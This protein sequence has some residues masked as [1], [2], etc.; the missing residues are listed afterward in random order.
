MR[1]KPET[2][3]CETSKGFVGYQV[4][5]DGPPDVVFVTNW[6][7]NVEVI[8]D[9]PAARRYLERLATIGRVLLIDKRGTGVSDP[10]GVGRV[11][12]VEEYVDDITS[13]M[14]EV[15]F[16]DSVLI[17]D[18]EG[19]TLALVLAATYPER[20]PSL[21]LINA[22]ARLRRDS[23][24]PIGAPHEVIDQLHEQWHS[25]VGRNADPLYVTAPSVA[26]DQ[27]FRA[28]WVHQVRLSMPPGVAGEAVRWIGDTD[29]RS[30]LPAIQARTLVMT[31]RDARLHRADFGRF[32]AEKISGAIYK[33][34]DGA[35]TLPF[36]A[37]NF[38][39]ILD[40]I[41]LFLTGE[42]KRVDSNR[43]LATVLF[44]DIVG[45][46]AIASEMGDDRWLDLR[47]AHD[48]IAEDNVERYRG[49]PIKATG[50]G[51]LATFDGPQRGIL[52]ALSMKEELGEIG[53]PIRAGLHTG[54][55]E[56][57]DDELGGLAVNIAS[58]VMDSAEMGGI[59]VSR[60]VKDLV[61]GSN[62]QF[63]GCGSHHLKGVDGE[64]DLFEVRRPTS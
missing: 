54:E 60:T 37:G 8:W 61:V 1:G 34:L 26:E 23:D 63:T 39:P 27:R 30:V 52:C 6:L 19:G 16:G 12:P 43:M 20:F 18:A 57:R 5:G 35:D 40:E 38:G 29:V 9:E 11:L 2:R 47:S 4:F 3:Y 53:V 21:V 28:S 25:M 31:R 42:R 44:T 7:T 64:W 50:D 51:L 32:L 46:T 13:V 10:H 15:G 48:R 14:D 24:Y 36:Y 58:R 55:V 59:M 33:E 62:L 56:M 22:F 45:S 49:A 17:G 41:E